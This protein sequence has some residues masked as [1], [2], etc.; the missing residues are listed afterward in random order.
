MT[1]RWLASCGALLMGISLTVAAIGQEPSALADKIKDLRREWAA[2][3]EPSQELKTAP[4][5]PAARQQGNSPTPT[6]G[7]G[8]PQIEPNSLVPNE[9]FS[10]PQVEFAGRSGAA[11]TGPPQPIA[12]TRRPAPS[13]PSIFAERGTMA[14]VATAR[15]SPTQRT[16][17][18]FDA[19]DLSLELS[20]LEP[21][22]P[23]PTT[24]TESKTGARLTGG[25]RR[26]CRRAGKRYG[27]ANCAQT[28][29][30]R[31]GADHVARPDLAAHE[32]TRHRE[33]KRFPK[34]QIAARREPGRQPLRAVEFGL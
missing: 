34:R 7:G 30:R 25:C 31:A 2:T 5:R 9:L 18:D 29:A 22:R 20:G 23:A 27:Q 33:P 13:R 6:R 26:L 14:P 24:S 1:R 21:D 32:H 17:V 10:A 12:D 8:L 16:H 11:R 28:D 3:D 15:R 19:D 4:P